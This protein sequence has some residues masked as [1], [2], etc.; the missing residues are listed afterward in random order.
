MSQEAQ[1]TRRCN[2]CL[3]SGEVGMECKCGNWIGVSSHAT[4]TALTE[5]RR[6]LTQI[7]PTKK[8]MRW[9]RDTGDGSKKI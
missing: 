4:E 2:I 7:T 5:M 6:R 1:H 9:L 3:Q 8:M